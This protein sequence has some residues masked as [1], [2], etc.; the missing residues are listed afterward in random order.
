[1]CNRVPVSFVLLLALAAPLAAQSTSQLDSAFLDGFRWRSIGP[2]NMSG[3]ITDIEGVPSPAKTFYVAAAG[4]GIWKTTNN[5]TTFRPV[6]DVERV[7]A[8]GDIAIA[9]SD[10]SVIWAGTGEEDSRNSIS[11][12]RGVYK[13][14][15]GGMTWQLMGLEET[16]AIGRIVIHPTNPDI[17]FVAALG[18]PWGTNEERGLYKTTDGGET[19][20]RV[21]AISERAGFVDIAMHPENPDVLFASSWER[22]RGPYF[23][24][25]GGPGSALWKSVDG[26]E[27][28]TEVTG[29][30]FPETMKGRIGIAIARSN[31]DIMYT[32]V[33]AEE[34][35]TEGM[36]DEQ[37]AVSG[38]MG[39]GLYRSEDGGRT[40][41][42]MND[43]NDR[44]FYYSQ[45]R[46]DPEDPDHVI[47][48]SISVTRDGGATV[49]RP[50]LGIHVDHHALWWDPADPDRFIDGNDGGIAQ[51]WDKGGS[52]DFI[53]TI[54]LGQF[55]AVSYNMDIPYR[56][57]GGLQDNGAWCGPSR[58]ADDELNNHMWAEVGGGDGFYSAQHPT[59]EDLIWVESQGGNM[60][61]VNIRT[62]E[63]MSVE[64][65]EWE[66]VTA[67]LRDSVVLL[68]D[69]DGDPVS[70]AAEA[71]L[72]ELRARIAADS[73]R[74]DLRFNWNTPFLLSPHDPDVFYAGAN[75][76]LK[77]TNGG[78]DLEVISP[79][80]TYA[81]TMKI[82]VSTET[83]G[84]ITPDVTGAETHATIVALDE[85]PLVPGMLYVGTDDGR[86]WV[87][88]DH[89]ANWEELTDRFQGVPQGTWVSR[90]EPSNHSPDRFYVT[91]DGHR[92][93]DFTPYVYVTDDG[94]RA[95][96]SI[97]NDL[98]TGGPDFVH[99]I[100]EDPYNPNLLFVGT[101]VGIYMSTD[102][103]GSWTRFMEG[104]P[105]VAVRD[106]QIHPRDRELIAGTHGQSVWIVDIA[107]LEQLGTLALNEGVVLF[108]PKPALQF[109]DRAVGGESTGNKVFEGENA[110]YGAEIT[111]WVPEG[112]VPTVAAAGAAA[113]APNG[114]PAQ[115]AGN[116]TDQRMGFARAGQDTVQPRAR[117][118]ILGTAGDTLETL[119]G[120]V[121]PGLHRVY[122]E[123]ERQ[124]EPE[125]LSPAERQDSARAAGVLQE[126][127]DSMVE[128]GSDPALVDTVL[129]SVASGDIRAL[130]QG[131]G[132]GED[133]EEAE[134]D[135]RPAESY[136][137]P[138]EAESEE[139]RA[140]L[141]EDLADDMLDEVR[142]RI[143]GAAVNALA[144]EG[145]QTTVE[146]GEYSVV[147]TLGQRSLSRPL[148][149]LRAEGYAPVD[150]EAPSLEE[151]LERG[152]EGE[153]DEY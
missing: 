139:S 74:Y 13:S 70:D 49:G 106:L 119:D 14:T 2:A 129:A 137:D 19:W 36:S 147:L 1:M 124:T 5:G 57:C 66:E 101:D 112:A 59:N 28:W 110:P 11:P 7:I 107:P 65:P 39:S 146:P 114:Q 73:A 16:Q 87:T 68:T 45:V 64:P 46:V 41:R 94:G 32:I 92:N 67:V 89:G 78:A 138:E 149:V 133:P 62:G 58:R 18:H 43:E 75:R 71:R 52:Y 8:M 117:I 98:P 76:V 126:V 84:G 95:F 24:D 108:A 69:E 25:G 132:G 118:A 127:A 4:G 136:P 77:S 109:G 42:F 116:T 60:S 144:P 140:E 120:P 3:R 29:G 151:L 91:F 90:I 63:R 134:F 15:D 96:R 38:Q 35:E 83:T 48:S 54:P 22:L 55:Y 61:R 33:E 93:D 86:V 44:P 150:E 23:F 85:S 125:P 26:G 148:T 128:A 20:Q 31:P 72:A 79:D 105:T 56:V 142:D 53:N 9:P 122:W 80:L 47:W 51:T 12:G 88:R 131:P 27:T 135:P 40:W 121:E 34:G 111:Y 97:A 113:S 100:R 123:L 81:D 6:F 130:L 103:G 37:A 104:M 153:G 115:G 102:R 143:G 99:V 50:A 145:E 82:R 21:K 141:L 17:V 30:G 152:E 10:T